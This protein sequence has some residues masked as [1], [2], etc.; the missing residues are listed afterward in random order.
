MCV[1]VSPLF[2]D[3][4]RYNDFSSKL[5]RVAVLVL[6][7]RCYLGIG[8]RSYKITFEAELSRT[9]RGQNVVRV[10]VCRWPS[11]T[12]SLPIRELYRKE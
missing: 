5:N 9:P 4:L 1:V 6:A 10:M 8:V 7:F 11:S 12:H 2:D 3:S